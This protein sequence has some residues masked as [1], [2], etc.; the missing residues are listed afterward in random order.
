MKRLNLIGLA[1]QPGPL[2]TLNEAAGSLGK[3][4]ACCQPNLRGRERY[5]TVGRPSR[6]TAE[7]AHLSSRPCFQTCD[8]PPS[9]KAQ[10]FNCAEMTERIQFVAM[11]RDPQRGY[12]SRKTDAEP[13][14]IVAILFALLLTAGCAIGTSFFLNARLQS[15]KSDSIHI[16]RTEARSDV[17]DLVSDVRQQ[18]SSD[19]DTSTESTEP[20]ET[21]SVPNMAPNALS[22][23]QQQSE[24][25]SVQLRIRPE[26]QGDTINTPRA[27][28]LEATAVPHIKQPI[29]V[30]PNPAGLQK[31][32]D[33]KVFSR[34][35]EQCRNDACRRAF[36]QC[37]QLCD[38]AMNM[39]VAACPRVSSG[40]S[41]QAERTCLAKRDRLRRYCHSGCA[42]R[43]QALKAK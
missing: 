3:Q 30:P 28:D 31:S 40:A 17:A 15:S 29:S 27:P 33:P 41:A 20:I 23:V 39:A 1:D 35:S 12:H 19:A 24:W 11:S 7:L 22:E 14:G 10:L 13:I 4:S 6:L 2:A 5:G 26:V 38:A 16:T 18:L 32:K 25:L 37:T 36:A 43:S 21:P 9:E 8:G 42:L 34:R